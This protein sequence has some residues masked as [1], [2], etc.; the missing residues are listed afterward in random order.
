MAAPAG[1][2]TPTAVVTD[3]FDGDTVQVRFDDGQIE[4]VRYLLI[5]TPELHHPLKGVEELGEEALRFNAELVEGREIVV[6]RDRAERDRYGRLL[7]H[8]R[9]VTDEGE[10]LVTAALIRAGLA[11]PLFIEPNDRHVERIEAA[12][13]EA[14]RNRRGLWGLAWERP[15]SA[16]QIWTFLA[17]LRGRFVRVRLD[18]AEVRRTRTRW[19]VTDADERLTLA[20]S[21]AQEGRFPDP[22]SWVGKTLDVIGK[23]EAGYRGVEISLGHPLQ[24]VGLSP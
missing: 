12:L 13:E 2:A 17:H 20:F 16:A 9:L 5:D 21:L 22:L 6:E 10:L 18:V 3:V 24:I 11:L 8:P 23:V 19:L 14:R 4:R 15:F 1:A 7:A